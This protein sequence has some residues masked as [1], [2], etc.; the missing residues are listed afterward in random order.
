MTQIS[1]ETEAATRAIRDLAM[2]TES[3]YLTI[4]DVQ[5][6]VMGVLYRIKRRAE[7]AMFLHSHRDAYPMVRDMKLRQ[8]AVRRILHHDAA[9]AITG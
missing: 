4:L 5:A 2:L 1:P 3:Q 6:P 8:D 9:L 7:N